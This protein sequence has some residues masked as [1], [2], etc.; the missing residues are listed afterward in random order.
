M[1]A[2]T[3][4]TASSRLAA[5]EALQFWRQVVRGEEVTSARR[6]GSAYT[7][8]DAF[9]GVPE[10][11]ITTSP[12]TWLAFPKSANATFEDIDADRLLQDEYVEWH[13]TRDGDGR[14]ERVVFSCEF[15][16][17]WGVLAAVSAEALADGIRDL[18]PEAD[19]S[20]EDLFGPGFDPAAATPTRRFFAF[21]D[22]LR[23]NPWNNGSPDLLCLEQPNNSLR[24][25]FK[26]VEDCGVH[27]PEIPPSSVCGEVACVPERN[28]DPFVCNAVQG[29]AADGRVLSFRDPVGIRI[30]ELGGI[31][32]LDGEEIDVNDPDAEHGVWKV[33]RN[34][35]RAVFTVRDGLTFDDDPI[36]T[37]AQIAQRLRVGVDV[38]HTAQDLVPGWARTG[39]ESSRIIT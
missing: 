15:R 9:D 38:V 24:A 14:L 21:L 4:P 32:K 35:R 6:P 36:L 1:F 11:S 20:V 8:L 2:Y 18:H 5:S 16:W 33:G 10:D 7:L 29:L 34:G 3:D 17:W 31:W 13:A 37:G 22:H 26:L 25:L 19:P 28:S 27:L 30:L 23:S 39:M 12:V